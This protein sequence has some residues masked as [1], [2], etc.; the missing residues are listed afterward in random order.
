LITFDDGYRNNLSRAMPILE[1]FSISAIFHVATEYVGQSNMYWFDELIER[2]IHWPHKELPS[3]NGTD[4]IEMP[5]ERRA[6]TLIADRV[7]E[8][9]KSIRDD[10][11]RKYLE[12]LRH[13]ELP[14]IEDEELYRCLDWN[15]IR[16]L[17]RRGFAIGSHTVSHPILTQLSDSE[18]VHELKSSKQT[19]E[20]ELNKP[21]RWIAF[22]NGGIHDVSAAVID[23]AANAGYEGAFTLR[24][25]SNR[26][27]L[28]PFE[29]DRLCVVR[30]LALD[31]FQARLSG[32]ATLYHRILP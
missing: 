26:L 12:V 9:C 8:E 18:L 28:K 30:D 22:P 24:G 17:D 19:I 14:C 2:V 1:A 7:R 11:R 25:N 16:D 13:E 3:P 21:C 23:A 10:R 6:R 27:P 5:K 32:L 4:R 31:A 15:G 20:E 29:I